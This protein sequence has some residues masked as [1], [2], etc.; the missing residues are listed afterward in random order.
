MSE[1]PYVQAA[2]KAEDKY[3]LS[4]SV[5]FKWYAPQWALDM[6]SD[7]PYYNNEG[8]FCKVTET[9]DGR[10]VTRIHLL[11]YAGFHFAVSVAPNFR[12]ALA[13]ACLHDWLYKYRKDIVIWSGRKDKDVLRLADYWFLSQMNASKFLLKRTYFY[14]VRSFGYYFTKWF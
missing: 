10:I 6:L 12:R 9:I 3:R 13:G 2:K 14:A 1:L 4:K 5:V 8:C 7:E 11:V